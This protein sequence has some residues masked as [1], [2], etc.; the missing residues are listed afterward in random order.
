MKRFNKKRKPKH[1]TEIR[2]NEWYSYIL[3]SKASSCSRTFRTLLG[4]PI[5]VK[6]HRYRGLG[7]GGR[8]DMRKITVIASVCQKNTDRR[9]R[10]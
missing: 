8:I 5:P 4:T 2:F 1:S 9:A 3:C 7:S 10:I 6:V